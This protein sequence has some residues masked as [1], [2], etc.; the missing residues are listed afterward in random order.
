MWWEWKAGSCIR[1]KMLGVGDMYGTSS[2]ETMSVIKLDAKRR[3]SL[4]LIILCL[5][6]RLDVS[7]VSFRCLY[8][9]FRPIPGLE[10]LTG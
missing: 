9:L 8:H 5:V 10:R 6:T 7:V 2:L 4:S 1:L 3:P